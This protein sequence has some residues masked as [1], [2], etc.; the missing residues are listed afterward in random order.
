MVNIKELIRQKYTLSQTK[1]SVKDVVKPRFMRLSL[2][3]A[4]EKFDRL[5]ME[6][7][8]DWS[9]MLMDVDMSHGVLEKF[10]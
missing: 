6:Y 8:T 4:I 3:N 1:E 5:P 7:R 10:S 9:K 2:E